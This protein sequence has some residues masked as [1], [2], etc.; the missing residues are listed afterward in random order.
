M[1][2][3][4]LPTRMGAAEKLDGF[5]PCTHGPMYSALRI[6]AMRA[7]LKR[8]RRID[9]GPRRQSDVSWPPHGWP[10]VLPVCSQLPGRV[11][12]WTTAQSNS[13]SPAVSRRGATPPCD[14]RRSYV[15]S[16]HALLPAEIIGLEVQQNHRCSGIVDGS[17]ALGQRRVDIIAFRASPPARTNPKAWYEKYLRGCAQFR[18]KPSAW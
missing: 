1:T 16:A 14:G 8:Q 15:D 3:L 5:L 2:R 6:F 4:S 13:R 17:V 7:R 12:A 18:I 10:A 9:K 11:S